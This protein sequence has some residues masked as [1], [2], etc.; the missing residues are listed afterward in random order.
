MKQPLKIN[1]KHKEMING[2]LH[3][4][5]IKKIKNNQMKKSIYRYC[6]LLGFLLLLPDIVYSQAKT[7]I[8]GTIHDEF[9]E[10][11]IGA[12]IIERSRD[13]RTLSSA[14]ADIDGN[15]SISVTNTS[16]VLVFRYVGY[17]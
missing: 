13:N 12:T 17:K 16:N 2:V 8:R 1:I 6:I 7:L 3:L 15:F 14:L 11:L 5:L 9:G 4:S 10:P